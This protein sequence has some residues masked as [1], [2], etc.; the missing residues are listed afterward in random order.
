MIENVEGLEEVYEA[1]GSV[2]GWSRHLMLLFLSVGSSSVLLRLSPSPR[3][4]RPDRV[5]SESTSISG[6]LLLLYVIAISKRRF[7]RFNELRWL[8]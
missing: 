3:Y 8:S 6:N 5:S 7:E 2:D 1:D 4:Q